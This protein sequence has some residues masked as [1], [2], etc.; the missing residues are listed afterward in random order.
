MQSFAF[1]THD[2][3]SFYFL[4]LRCVAICIWKNHQN[5]TNAQ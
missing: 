1:M 2:S 5:V 4:Q 3:V